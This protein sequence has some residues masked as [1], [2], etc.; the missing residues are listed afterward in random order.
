[1]TETQILI[2]TLGTILKKQKSRWAEVNRKNWNHTN[3]NIIEINQ[4]TEKS[5]G[6]LR[7]LA[8]TQTPVKN[9][10]FELVWKICKE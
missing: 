10:Y 7:R 6:N 3:N 8:V 4:D 9:K 5:S 1:M 2:R